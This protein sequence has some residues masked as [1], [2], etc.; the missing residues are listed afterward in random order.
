MGS[1]DGNWFRS[2]ATSLDQ[3]GFDTY[4]P[5]FPT[6]DGQDLENW[7]SRFAGTV[8]TLDEQSLLIG[9]SVGAVFVM[10]LLERLERPVRAA[11]LVAGF[12]GPLGLPEYDQL[13]SSFVSAPFQWDKIRAHAK[14]IICISGDAD[15]YVPAQHGL[16]IANRL[17]VEPVVIE[18]GGHLNAESGFT[19]FPQLLAALSNAGVLDYARNS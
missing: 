17:N 9:H 11:V 10:R 14:D 12:I 7:M 19:S 8:G 15:P 5:Q 4:V 1:P 2:I 13:N 18:G 6:P 16:E 3:A